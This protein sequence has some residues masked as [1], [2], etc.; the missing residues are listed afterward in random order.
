VANCQAAASR[1]LA[2]GVPQGKVRVIPNGVEAHAHRAP[3]RRALPRR[4]VVVANLRRE[5]GHDVLLRAAADVVRAFPDARVELVGGGPEL[6]ALRRLAD[7]LGLERVVS[8]LGHREDVTSRLDAADLF[9]LPS[10]SEAFPNAMLEAM[11][12]GLP[13]V[14]S[15]VGGVREVVRHAA[16]GLIVPAGD[17]GALASAIRRLMADPPFAHGLGDAARTEVIARYSFDRMIDQFEA[18]YLTELA[19]GGPVM[20]PEPALAAS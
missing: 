10:R 16:T 2:E 6:P 3:D 9:V 4:V 7:E 1:L 12:A 8:F 5:K 20:P 18:L 15:D 19:R 13:V 17:A 11:A 14:A